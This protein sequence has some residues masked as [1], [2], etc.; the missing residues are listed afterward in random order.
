MKIKFVNNL[1]NKLRKQAEE[2]KKTGK[3]KP[4]KVAELKEQ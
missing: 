2:F 4:I 1:M 3:S